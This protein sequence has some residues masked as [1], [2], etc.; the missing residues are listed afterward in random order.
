MSSH[1]NE[2]GTTL[3]V[4]GGDDGALAFLLANPT[5][6][7]VS[8]SQGANTSPLVL[9]N[10][11][12]GSAVTA[13]TVVAIQSHIYVLTSGN[14][15]WIRLWEV[16]VDNCRDHDSSQTNIDTLSVKRLSKVKT[17]VADVS[18]MAVLNNDE[19]TAR[20]LVCGV[21]MEVVRLDL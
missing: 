7:Q 13:C 16:I 14:D 18:S 12:H 21:G 19:I 15:E 3:I 20:V 9:V 8:S 4:S 2:D 6:P 11:A 17:S 10:R 1:V 5:V